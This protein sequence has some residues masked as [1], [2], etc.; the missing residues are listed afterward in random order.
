[1]A[2]TDKLLIIATHGPAE[3][4]LATIPFVV[5]CAALASD[6][7]VAM[8]FQA[9]GVL[10]V[11][12]GGAEPVSLPD[13]PPLAKLIADYQEL[14]GSLL[15]CSP[16]LKTRGIA[17]DSLLAGA[18]VIAASRLVNEIMEAHSTVTY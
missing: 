3:P 18:E 6:V 14:G 9:D 16:C 10:L 4:E 15:V 12:T 17:A 5:G 13:F 8:V 7:P 2:E 1:M 11:K